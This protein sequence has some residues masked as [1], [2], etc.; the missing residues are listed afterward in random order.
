MS[1]PV[2]SASPAIDRRSAVNVWCAEG[3]PHTDR[4]SGI[5]EGGTVGAPLPDRRLRGYAEIGVASLILGTSA[6]LIQISTMPASLLVVLRMALAVVALELIF[7]FASI[8]LANVTVGVSLEYMAPVFVAL[9]APW[10]LRTRRQTIDM[11]AVAV[12]AG[13]VPIGA[14][15]DT[16]LEGATPAGAP[17]E[18]RRPLTSSSSSPCAGD[19]PRQ[20]EEPALT[21]PRALA[22]ER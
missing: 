14:V 8:R 10:V 7:F 4:R 5:S 15:S 11:V 1:S 20:A 2:A 19:G 3:A 12:A 18:C 6:T 17:A 16:L 13:G 9:L 21:T 22:R